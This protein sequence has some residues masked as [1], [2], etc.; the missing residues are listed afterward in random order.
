[1]ACSV[2]TDFDSPVP[3]ETCSNCSEETL[4]KRS[5]QK[6]RVALARAAY[7]HADVVADFSNIFT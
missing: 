1:M 3:P 7:S 5:G 2:L 6:Q 4:L